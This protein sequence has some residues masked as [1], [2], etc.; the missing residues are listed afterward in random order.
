M[1]SVTFPLAAILV[2]SSAGIDFLDAPEPD[3]REARAALSDICAD[4]ER[5]S[6]AELRTAFRASWWRMTTS[7]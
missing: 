4:T 6:G 2:N 1:R 5:A 7:R 3:L